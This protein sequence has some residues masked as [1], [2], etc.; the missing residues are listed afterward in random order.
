MFKKLKYAKE[1]VTTTLIRYDHKLSRKAMVKGSIIKDV[2]SFGVKVLHYEELRH[3]GFSL[4]ETTREIK[5]P[6][7]YITHLPHFWKFKAK[8]R[9]KK[10]SSV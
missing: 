5:N 9:V 6:P 2:E 1:R 7:N 4:V 10:S 8:Y 3:F